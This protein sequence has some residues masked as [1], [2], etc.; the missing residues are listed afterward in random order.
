MQN[1]TKEQAKAI[2]RKRA[3]VQFTKS[4]VCKKIGISEKTFNKIE[5]GECLVKPTVYAK[6]MEWLAK[7]Y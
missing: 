2:R 7:D 4:M 3:D 5:N 6:V 1:I